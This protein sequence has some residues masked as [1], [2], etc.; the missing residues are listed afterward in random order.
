MLSRE[1]QWFEAMQA[2]YIE[3]PSKLVNT[4]CYKVKNCKTN[5]CESEEEP[6]VAVVLGLNALAFVM[7]G[8]LVMSQWI[9][10]PY[11]LS[12]MM[13]VIGLSY[14]P[15]LLYVIIKYGTTNVQMKEE[16]VKCH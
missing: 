15:C 9:V 6:L 2:E 1:E 5:Q 7:I 16:G 12:F 14:L 4:T 13:V 8:F 11:R 3:P 10:S